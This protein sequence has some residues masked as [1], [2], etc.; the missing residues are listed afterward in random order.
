MATNTPF[1]PERRTTAERMGERGQAREGDLPTRVQE[2]A[3]E[4]AD[5]ARQKAR[6]NLADQKERATS[7]IDSVT[8]ALHATS[9]NLRDEHQDSIAG[10]VDSAADQLERVSSYVRSRSVGELMDDIQ[11]AARREPALFIGGAAMLGIVG[12][13]FLKSSQRRRYD[14]DYDRESGYERR[15]MPRR[16]DFGDRDPTTRRTSDVDYRPHSDGA[17]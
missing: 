16:D 10:F 5:R 3:S 15:A 6:E 9:S 4:T 8:S 1:T 2:Q 14:G 7:Q 12:A 17:W 13:R 11:D